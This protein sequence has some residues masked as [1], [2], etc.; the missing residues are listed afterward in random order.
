MQFMI[1]HTLTCTH[2]NKKTKEM[3]TSEASE[4]PHAGTVYRKT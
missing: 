4:E 3:V 2:V 1:L